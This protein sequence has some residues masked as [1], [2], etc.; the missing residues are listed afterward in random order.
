MVTSKKFLTFDV[1]AE[2]AE[3]ALRLKDLQ[4]K[5]P[6]GKP[7]PAGGGLGF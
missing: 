1:A 3:V 6:K 7:G 2:K 4:L 5:R